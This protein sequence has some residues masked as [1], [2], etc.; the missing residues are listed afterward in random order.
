MHQV[1]IIRVEENFTHGTFGVLLLNTSAFCVTLEPPDI[2]NEQNLSSI[3]AQQYMVEMTTSP[4]YGNV[5]EIQN[6]P[7]RSH[8]L[9]HAGNTEEHTEGCILLGRNFGRLGVDRAILCSGATLAEFHQALDFK[10][11]HLTIKEHY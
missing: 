2:L 6:V 7:G 4:K 5:Y 1:R 10:P 9:F 3:P 11:F 8:C